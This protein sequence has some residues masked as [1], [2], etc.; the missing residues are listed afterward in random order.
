MHSIFVF[1]G[2]LGNTAVGIDCR[3]RSARGSAL[4][5]AFDSTQP[6]PGGGSI[7]AFRGAGADLPIVY[8]V[9]AGDDP[10]GSVSETLR[11]LAP[12]VH[13]PL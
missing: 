13:S 3:T 12:G 11:A 2:S 1:I 10:E 6:M 8:P 9:A 5:T 7:D 4:V